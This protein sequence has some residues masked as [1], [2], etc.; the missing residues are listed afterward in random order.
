MWAKLLRSAS[1]QAARGT[2]ASDKGNNSFSCRALEWLSHS[3]TCCYLCRLCPG[4]R[5]EDISFQ[6]SAQAHGAGHKKTGHWGGYKRHIPQKDP[7]RICK[8]LGHWARVTNARNQPPR[9]LRSR[10]FH[11]HSSL[12]LGST[13]WQKING[14]SIRCLLYSGC[15]KSVI[16]RSL[17]PDLHLTRSHYILSAANKTDLSILRDMDLHFTTDGHK[18]VANV[19][20]SPAI[21]EFLL[22]SDVL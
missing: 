5:Y 14:K 7:C 17:I 18:F 4:C 13:W 12:S 3:A 2:G 16:A 1:G 10:V 6:Q 9:A 8:Q 22:G 15:E 20:V 19:S 21:D 11:F